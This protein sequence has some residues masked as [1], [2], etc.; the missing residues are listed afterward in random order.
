MKTKAVIS[1]ATS[2][3]GIALINELKNQGCDITAV[4]RPGSSRKRIIE[5]EC[6]PER[7]VECNI[8]NLSKLNE[9]L[10]PYSDE[11]GFDAFFHIGW[12][13][14]FDNPRFNIEG[15]MHNVDYAVDAMRVAA[16]LGC[17]KFLGVGSQAECGLVGEP[18]CFNTP[19]NPITAY[20]EAKC[21]TYRKCSDLGD[22]L[23]LD[24]YWPRLLSAYGPYDRPQTLVMSCIDACINHKEIAMSGAEQI[25]DYVYV[26]DVAKAL[27]LIIE[28]G[29][30]KKKYPIASGTGR[31]LRDYIRDIADVYDYPALMNGIGKRPYA[32]NEVMH[33]VG[34][35]TE[36]Y[37][38]TGVVFDAD[39]KKHINHM[40]S[41]YLF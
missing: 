16:E 12:S 24:F 23:G 38:D 29:V 35:V 25:W 28:K 32:V 6:K 3:I 14:D 34:D 13:S 27:S 4:I 26:D 9:I 17:K 5:K 30:P 37:K 7:I 40:K 20:A 41:L 31:P 15:Q 22:E 18:I 36:L 33:L 11:H 39:F 21:E 1:G 19:E 2:F 10:S 8:N